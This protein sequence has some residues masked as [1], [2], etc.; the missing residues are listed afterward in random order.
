MIKTFKGRWD[1]FN[2]FI[3]DDD[4]YIRVIPSSYLVEEVRNSFPLDCFIQCEV[5]K[6]RNKDKLCVLSYIRIEDLE[7]DSSL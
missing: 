5:L 7:H 3:S 1:S 4:E 2:T 6:G